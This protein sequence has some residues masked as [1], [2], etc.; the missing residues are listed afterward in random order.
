MFAR[1]SIRAKITSVIAFLLIVMMVLGVLAVS[2]MRSINSSAAEIET[3]WL[4]KVRTLGE[5]RVGIGIY[6]NMIR[7]HLLNDAASEKDRMAG[8]MADRDQLN[9]KIREKYE[10]I[11]NSPEE[12]ALFND[13][14][15]QWDIYKKGTEEVIARSRASAG[16]FAAEAQ[17]LHSKTVNPISQKAEELLVAA[18]NLNNKG[19][20]DAGK[21]AAGTF[22][23]AFMAQAIVLSIAALLGLGIGV[24]LVRDVSSGIASIVKPM[25]ALGNG[26]LTAVV[27]HQGETTEI[28]SM[29]DALQVFKQALIDK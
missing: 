23:F 5:L 24:Y 26:D 27:P 22:D 7:E 15:R 18:V 28:G 2:S 9:V 4:P 29:A 3:V 1:L 8:M 13:W 14:K 19:A 25:Q 11:I 6:R 12:R 17:T 10:S 16:K 20:A 21:H